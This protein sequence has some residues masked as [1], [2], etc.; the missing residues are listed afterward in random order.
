MEPTHAIKDGLAS[1]VMPAFNASRFIRDAIDSVVSQ[2]CQEWELIVVDDCSQDDTRQIIADYARDDRR[3]RLLALSLNSGV[4]AARRAGIAAAKG[5]Y[6]AFLDSDDLWLPEKLAR[7]IDFMRKTDAAFSYTSFR[8]MSENGERVSDVA[9]VRESFD[10]PALLKNT[11]I[12]CLTVML[13]MTKI[14]QMAVLDI[15]HEDY[16]MWLAIL[17]RGF[18]AKGLPEDLARYRVVKG[19]VSGMKLKSALWVWKIYRN[20]KLSIGRSLY[21]LSCYAWHAFRKRRSANPEAKW[22]ACHDGGIAGA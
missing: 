22:V 2:T 21:C 4:A 17:K 15:R 11:G 3:I 5:Q 1:I 6:I 8:R 12:A 9:R 19:S 18:V 16:A 20:E 10:Y 13:D 7:Q 14:G